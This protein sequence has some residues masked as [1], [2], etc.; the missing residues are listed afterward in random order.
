MVRSISTAHHHEEADVNSTSTPIIAGTI[1]TITPLIVNKL[2]QYNV[3]IT[4]IIVS[5]AYT[6][7]IRSLHRSSS[8][9]YISTKESTETK[10]GKQY[11]NTI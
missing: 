6:A 8:S 11:I 2:G 4:V 7:T 9:H 10:T 5:A 3:L 1:L